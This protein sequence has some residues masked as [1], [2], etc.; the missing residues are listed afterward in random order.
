M[1]YKFVDDLSIL[2]KINLL[3]IGLSSYYFKHHVASDISTDHKYIPSENL[4]S[5]QYLKKVEQWTFQNKGKLNV[6]KTKT[7]IFNFCLDHQFQ[8]RLYVENTLLETIRETKLLGT[9][10]TDDLKWHGNTQMLVRKGYTRMQI[11]HKLN[12][13]NVSR[14]D[15][16]EIYVLYI[17]SVLEHNCQVWHFSLTEEDKCS[18]ERVQKVAFRLIL[19]SDDK[20]Y[21]HALVALNMDSLDD[22]R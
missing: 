12:S 15:L 17:R 19:G 5:Q 22:R 11:I 4:K 21:Q 1:K 16:K 9:V 2:E 20:D 6:Q 8:T 3:L 14:E 10:I 13:F 7:M 18:L